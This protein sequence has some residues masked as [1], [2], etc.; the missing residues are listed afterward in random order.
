MSPRSTAVVAGILYYFMFYQQVHTHTQTGR[1]G[2][3]GG[4]TLQKRTR[5]RHR[6]G[7]RRRLTTLV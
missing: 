4:L 1:L 7:F 6:P 3:S 2:S 5:S